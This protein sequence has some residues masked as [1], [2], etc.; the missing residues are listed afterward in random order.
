MS[1]QRFSAVASVGS[2]TD[3]FGSTK[4]HLPSSFFITNS[5]QRAGVF[6]TYASIIFV[7]KSSTASANKSNILTS[8]P[9]LLYSSS[10]I[11]SRAN[12][13]GFLSSGL[14]TKGSGT[15]RLQPTNSLY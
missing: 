4:Y 3:G 1:R 13:A 6:L 2:P 14:A 10:S 8:Y 11:L 15:S 12:E 5:S 9:S 7:Y